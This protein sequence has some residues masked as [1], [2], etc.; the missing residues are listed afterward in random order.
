MNVMTSKI[1]AAFVEDI[2]SLK[3][4][5]SL[6]YGVGVEINITELSKIFNKHRNTI[7][8]KIDKFFEHN[9]IERPLCSFNHIFDKDSIMVIEKGGFRREL[10]TNNWIEKDPCIWNAYFV[11]EDEYNTLLLILIDDLFTYDKWRE[12][13]EAESK[14][15]LGERI[16][17]SDPIF[18]STKS[19]LKFDPNASFQLLEANFKNKNSITIND[20]ELDELSIKLLGALLIGQGIRINE[21]FLARELDINRRT[22]QRRI[23]SLIENNIISPPVCRFPNLW[24]PPGYFQVLSLIEIKKEKSQIL[25]SLK[26]DPH[27]PF[28][29]TANHRKYNLVM[30]SVFNKMDE[31]LLWQ[32]NYDQKFPNSFGAIKNTYLSPAMTFPIDQGYISMC[33]I[34]NLI[35]QIQDEPKT[36]FY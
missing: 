11:K 9:V 8:N 6:V 1:K 10:K 29:I 5:E 15:T 20:L 19:I 27:I 21:N 18:L 34:Q 2:T 12:S 14:I 28:L 30:F 35:N 13:I 33:Y 31:H 22:A 36:E 26:Q 3:I 24:G 7:T 17:P 16:Y 23:D 4:L 32:E 25:N